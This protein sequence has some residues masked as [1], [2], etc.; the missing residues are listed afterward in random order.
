MTRIE[1]VELYQNKRNQTPNPASEILLSLG[2]ESLAVRKDNDR[3]VCV[4]YRGADVK[5]GIA[6][7]GL[8]GKGGNFER[9]CEDY[10]KQIRGKTLVFNAE[11]PS[12]HEVRVLG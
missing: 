11:S 4:S 1:F 3:N 9:A 10:L 5:D 8:Y 6:L 7:V 2:G 12:R